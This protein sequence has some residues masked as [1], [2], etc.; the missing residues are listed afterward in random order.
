[1]MEALSERTEQVA[2]PSGPAKL[3]PSYNGPFEINRL[4]FDRA[5]NRHL[6]FGEGGHYCLGAAL[7]GLRAQAEETNA[8]LLVRF[9]ALQA[10]MQA[11]EVIARSAF[12]ER[13]RAE[14]RAEFSENCFSDRRAEHDSVRTDIVNLEHE[15]GALRQSG[16]TLTAE[17]DRQAVECRE[18]RAELGQTREKYIEQVAR[19]ASAESAL[20]SLEWRVVENQGETAVSLPR[21]VGR[22]SAAA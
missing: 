19:A 15:I 11:A 12:A 9:D 21:R 14:T 17:L 20:R 16:K 4:N 22:R 6:T 13:A 7:A 8:A 2:C 3:K 10:E 18:T 1:M 5:P